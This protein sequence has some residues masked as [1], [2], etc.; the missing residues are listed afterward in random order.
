MAGRLAENPDESI[1][2]T[3]RE[4]TA[5]DT[6]DAT[7][8]RPGLTGGGLGDGAAHGGSGTGL[9]AVMSP[10]FDVA[11][12]SLRREQRDAFRMLGL[13]AGPD[14]TPTA[15]S[16]LQNATA[17]E[18]RERLEGLRQASLVQDVGPDRYRMHDLLRD[19][20]RQQGL[21]EDSD[22]EQLAA[23]QRLLAR[24][25]ADARDAGSAL[26][27][28]PAPPRTRR[29]PPGGR[30][31]ATPGGRARPGGTRPGRARRAGARRGP[32]L[33]RGG[34][35]QPRRRRAPGGPASGCTGRA[36]SSPT[37]S[38]SRSSA[39]T[40]RT[41][42]PST[43]RGCRRRTE[44]DWAA[45]AV[46]LH[47]LAM[48]HFE[49]GD[50]VQAIGYGEDAR[51]ALPGR[52]PARPVRGGRH[53]RHPGGRPRGAARPVPH[54]DPAGPA[55][56]ADPRGD[57][58]PQERGR[59]RQGTRHPRA[60]VPGAR[61][62]REGAGTRRPGP[63]HMAAHRHLPGVAETLL[64]IAQVHRTRATPTRA[65]RMPW[66]PSTSGKN[67]PTCTAPPGARNWRACTPRSAFATCAQTPSRPGGLLRLPGSAP[68]GAPR[69][70]HWPGCRATPPGSPRRSPLRAGAAPEPQHQR[71]PRRG[72]DARADR[73]RALAARRYRRRA[74]ASCAHWRSPGDRR[75]ARRGP[76]TSNTS[77]W[78][79]GASA[80]TRRRSSSA[81]RRS[82]CG[83]SS[84]RRAAWPGRSAAWPAPTPGSG[85][86]GT[87]RRRRPAGAGDPQLGRRLA[88]ARRRHGHP[89]RRAAP[90]GPPE[91]AL[92]RELEALR[93]LGEVGDRHGEGTDLVH[94][95]GIHLDLGRADEALDTGRRPTSS[96]P[97]SATPG[98]RRPRCTTWP[99]PPA[100][101]KHFRAVEHFNA[102]IG[103]RR[104]L[105][106][107]R[108]MRRALELL[109]DSHLALGD[110]TAA[111]DCVRRV[112]AL[113]RGSNPIDPGQCDE[114][115]R[116]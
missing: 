92:E 111:A 115:P 23:Q 46:M 6:E 7:P 72:R 102:E 86:P 79:C 15:L 76:P 112:R 4:L 39:A 97:S 87:P 42:S 66:R 98:R 41:T 14:F 34:A 27:A 95:A 109:R 20:A 89:R 16:A 13:V 81:W 93:F 2:A 40:A 61:R 78:S 94:L 31:E 71:P 103:V 5:R 45:A 56:P 77:R 54:G 9:Q 36:G 47:H 104:D 17:G 37:R 53:P 65:C 29:A 85:C 67:S 51:R 88:R 1:A 64:T 59:G 69:S 110:E 57:R 114:Q 73:D 19:F 12:R 28:R 113:D 38:T 44:E 43:R 18:A 99:G 101:G 83:T 11:Y 30:R 84:A 50:C 32:R 25:L 100:T 58:R 70:P 62:V 105:D 75:P 24:Y 8:Y 3:V 82:T 60:R 35:P 22:A 90:R 55:V 52:R 49:L 80:A 108:G 10:T 116:M 48:A 96:P 21:R 33:V 107:Q 74:S 106:D 68:R 63:R 26:A 91:E